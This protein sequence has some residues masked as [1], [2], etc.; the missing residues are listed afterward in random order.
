MKRTKK[1]TSTG[2][3]SKRYLSINTSLAP[4]ANSCIQRQQQKTK[5]WQWK[6]FVVA[7]SYEVAGYGKCDTLR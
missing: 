4:K 2:I 7:D 6:A 1:K 3:K 5:E